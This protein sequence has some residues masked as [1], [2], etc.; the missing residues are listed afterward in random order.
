RRAAMRRAFGRRIAL[1]LVQRQEQNLVLTALELPLQHVGSP[2][3]A[4]GLHLLLNCGLWLRRD[5]IAA[6]GADPPAPD[7]GNHF[8]ASPSAVGTRRGCLKSGTLL[9]ARFWQFSRP[10]L[11]ARA[12]P[13]HPAGPPSWLFADRGRPAASHPE[14]PAET[15]RAA[16]IV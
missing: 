5:G 1:R 10:D 4:S 3:G 2:A 12:A 11:R 9:S 7:L 8:P 15:R 16:A 6:L 14:R 13:L